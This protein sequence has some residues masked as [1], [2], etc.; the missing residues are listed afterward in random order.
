MSTHRYSNFVVT[1]E[2]QRV[3]LE[4]VSILHQKDG[5][6]ENI[7]LEI[8]QWRRNSARKWKR[9]ALGKYTHCSSCCRFGIK[10]ESQQPLLDV[11]PTSIVEFNF[12]D[13]EQK[14]YFVLVNETMER[15]LQR[16][17]DQTKKSPT[18][19]EK[20]TSQKNVENLSLDFKMRSFSSN[21]EAHVCVDVQKSCAES[22]AK[23]ILTLNIFN[24]EIHHPHCFRIITL[25]LRCT[26]DDLEI[27]RLGLVCLAHVQ[28]SKLMSEEQAGF[29]LAHLHHISVPDTYENF[30]LH[31]YLRYCKQLLHYKI[32]K[33]VV[34]TSSFL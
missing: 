8:G 11:N 25:M 21:L 12:L 7:A 27:V 34:E 1:G 31:S 28:K 17:F 22:F 29:F 19:K 30:N 4:V 2:H 33:E 23:Y 15:L 24:D 10:V 6:H 32:D 16:I 3:F 13:G 26:S 14:D 18:T 5:L 20:S 9:S